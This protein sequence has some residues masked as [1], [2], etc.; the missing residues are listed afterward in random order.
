ML[1][2]VSR[3][4]GVSGDVSTDVIGDVSIERIGVSGDVR[5]QM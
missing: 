3:E 5:V 1:G 4:N 2:D